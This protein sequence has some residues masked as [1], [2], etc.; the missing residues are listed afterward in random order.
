[1]AASGP[2]MMHQT[3][4][5][6]YYGSPGVGYPPQYYQSQSSYQQSSQNGYNSVAPPPSLNYE[7]EIKQK[8]LELQDM[9]ELAESIRSETFDT[10]PFSARWSCVCDPFPSLWN[11]HSLRFRAPQPQNFSP[12]RPQSTP[13]PTNTMTQPVFNPQPANSF[14]PMSSKFVYKPPPSNEDQIEQNNT[15]I[16]QNQ[17]PNYTPNY[18]NFQ[19]KGTRRYRN[20]PKK[21]RTGP[22]QF[23]YHPSS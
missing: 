20:N 11:G 13:A 17:Q 12:K 9:V 16:S 7:S 4:Y 15:T 5:N 18:S 2:Q 21:R 19:P 23:S 8:M 10:S 22:D 3:P 1:M 6:G 14:Q